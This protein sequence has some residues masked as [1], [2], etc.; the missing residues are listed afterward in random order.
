MKI[1]KMLAEVEIIAKVERVRWCLLNF[2]KWKISRRLKNSIGGSFVVS[3]H[4]GFE[5]YY[6]K[7]YKRLVIFFC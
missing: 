3:K 7:F 1:I 4:I 2:W 6:A 5:A